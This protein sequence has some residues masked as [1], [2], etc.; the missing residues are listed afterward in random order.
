MR[1]PNRDFEYIEKRKSSYLYTTKNERK[2]E[3]IISFQ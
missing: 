1:T 3:E 2:K